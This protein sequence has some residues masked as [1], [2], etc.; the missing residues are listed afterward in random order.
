M[1]NGSCCFCNVNMETM[2]HLLFACKFS[3]SIWIHILNMFYLSYLIRLWEEYVKHLSCKWKANK[4]KYV[5]EKLCFGATIY[6]L[7]RERNSRVFGGKCSD[8]MI[9]VN[10]I[11]TITRERAMD[12]R[13]IKK[14][15]ANRRL[16]SWWRLPNTIC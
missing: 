5:L 7:W 9:I 11:K 8:A 14:S 16:A 13:K 12:L 4:L 15:L 1:T 2:D 6:W 3:S 10:L